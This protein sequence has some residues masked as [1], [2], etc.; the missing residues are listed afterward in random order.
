M[1][2]TLIFF[3]FFVIGMFFYFANASE[4]LAQSC[5]SN[6]LC[7]QTM[8]TR[9]TPAGCTP[10]CVPPGCTVCTGTENYCSNTG[11]GVTCHWTGGTS[12]AQDAACPAGNYSGGCSYSGPPP[13]PPGPPPPPPPGG[14]T[15]NGACFGGIANCGAVGRPDGSGSCPS[16]E[17]CCGNPSGGGNDPGPQQECSISLPAVSV[18]VGG[19]TTFNTCVNAGARTIKTVSWTL[20]S[21]T[22]AILVII[23]PNNSFRVYS[24]GLGVTRTTEFTRT[25]QCW[26][27]S[28]QGI[29]AGTDSLTMRC[30][31]GNNS[32]LLRA[33]RTSTVTV[34][35]GSAPPP[36]PPPAPG[37]PVV[38]LTANPTTVITNG[39]STLSWSTSNATACTASNGWSGAKAT[40]GS[41]SSGA[42][43]AARTFTL[44]C[45]G[46]GGSANRSV[47][48]NV[49]ATAP[50]P[51]PPG[52]PTVD[53]RVNG[54]NGPLT[55]TSGQSVTLSWTTTLATS[56]TASASVATAGWSGSKVI[57][58]SQSSGALTSSR[59]FT[60][61]C[62]GTGGSRSD[63]VTVST[64]VSPPPPPPPP[65]ASAPV[66]NLT[67]NG[68]S[69]PVTVTS[70]ST[71]TTAWSALNAGSCTAS[72]SVATGNWSGTVNS[73][74]SRSGVGPITTNRSLILTCT[75][76]G[77]T[78]SRAVAVNVA[79]VPPP[80]PPLLVTVDLRVN[81]SNGP[82][83]IPNPGSITLSWSSTN[84]TSCAASG[85]W[86]GSRATSGTFGITGI[87]S[88]RN[89][90][91]TC[92]RSGG[93]ASDTVTVNVLGL[94]ALPIVDL[95]ANGSSGPI[96]VA[97][98]AS[99]T[100][101][102][103][104]AN[105]TTCTASGGWSGA[106]A[107]SGSQSSGAIPANRVFT[108][109]CTGPGGSSS[110]TVNVNVAASGAPIV[111]LRANGLGSSATIPSGTAANLS[112]T[113]T[114]ATTCTA[115]GGWSGSKIIA[116][117]QSTG[118]LVTTTTYILTCSG[119]GGNGVDTVTVNIGA[120]GAA[121]S[122]AR[123]R[124][125]PSTT[126]SVGG[127]PGTITWAWDAV[128]GANQYDVDIL[129]SAGVVVI[130]SVFRPAASFGPTCA[131]G[132]ICTYT[133]SHAPG[134]SV[135]SRIVALG[136]ACSA[137]APAFSQ[138]IS[139]G[140]CATCN[141]SVTPDPLNI[142]VGQSQL[143]AAN[144]I[145]NPAGST[146]VSEVDF[147]S[148][149]TTVATVTT[150]DTTS[151][152]TTTVSGNTIGTSTINAVAT[153]ATGGSCTSVPGNGAEVNVIPPG[154]WWQV[155]NGSVTSGGSTGNLTSLIP[156]SCTLP[157]C[158]PLFIL[159]GSAGRPGTALYGGIANNYDFSSNT[160]N[161]GT[162]SST[163]WISNTT[164]Q[165]QTSD[166]T[167]IKSLLTT[168]ITANY[169]NL[170][171]SINNGNINAAPYK[172]YSWYYRSGDMS[173]DN[174]INIAG[175]KAVIIIEGGNLTIN[176]NINIANPENSFILIV[177]GRN[178]SGAGGN[179]IIDPQVTELQGLFIVDGDFRTG[180]TGAAND[181]RLEVLG[182]VS[183][184]DGVDLQRDLGD[185]NV[186][187]PAEEFTYD[188]RQVL[189][190]PPYLMSDLVIWKEVAP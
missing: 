3:T 17:R 43:P 50:P 130:P 145:I 35:G 121:C 60:L 188:P 175:E 24:G 164:H 2:K 112:W 99:A 52:T 6:I 27:M 65:P 172:G 44:T 85:S 68:S 46:P 100:L 171:A 41:Q 127:A 81:G 126:C 32:T 57:N 111:D 31:S 114:N 118:I 119:P 69:G 93:S 20:G 10:G 184:L 11:G 38:N 89:F 189:Q 4:T 169:N 28:V 72:A 78:A 73:G 19:T 151:P 40:S 76:P 83:T 102:W 181:T 154:P 103:T 22:K 58:G 163:N 86:G 109:T 59:N 186:N 159:N 190:F 15:C 71:V 18:A 54:G 74:G 174:P 160:T 88:S 140:P 94:P 1:K 152:F 113:T 166:W 36:P 124:D 165:A 176:R 183:A 105:A 133:T 91:L 138:F 115:S 37:A 150:P 96:T 77:G 107:T 108:L 144:V 137:S 92:I 82:V 64:S 129:N 33:S 128:A 185:G 182:A 110:D 29:A 101:S 56:C 45:T 147:S 21:I 95:R 39:S 179:I 139:V 48:V 34:T 98:G 7:C 149:N 161:R 9:R 80:P 162:V 116:G 16:G 49:S 125:P 51:P 156:D 117:S 23:P 84:A 167:Y 53:L 136:L 5:S 90:T 70:G 178:S 155:I 42:I 187:Q 143:M 170:P 25:T 47:T 8:S 153:L 104:A 67:V 141:I 63:T 157:G 55:I 87:N 75:G 142:E 180:T 134:I 148:T 13:P 131:S 66:V 14:S 97:A 146:T 61:N 168:D 106:K 122:P 26:N 177:V 132:G 62:T 120:G 158:N 173:I 123:P 135:R 30:Y 12:C 79:A